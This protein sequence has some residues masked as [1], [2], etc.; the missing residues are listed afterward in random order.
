MYSIYN[1]DTLEQFI[2]TMHKMHNKTTWNE[3]YL[4]VNLIIGIIGIYP[5]MEFATM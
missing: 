1:S 4:P 3:N 2:D 5:N